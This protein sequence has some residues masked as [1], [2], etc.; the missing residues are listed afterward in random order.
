MS[1]MREGM[2]GNRRLRVPVSGTVVVI[3]LTVAQGLSASDRE[4]RKAATW[5]WPSIARFEESFQSYL[6]QRALPEERRREVEAAWDSQSP[7]STGPEA[8]DH[9]LETV[10]LADD[11]FE[12]IWLQLKKPLAVRSA[13]Q[14][15]DLSWWDASI[16]PWIQ[17][18]FR[19]GVARYLAHLQFYDESLQLLNQIEVSQVVDP[20]T[21]FFYRAVCHHHLLQKDDCV[22]SIK[23]MMERESELASR[24]AITA[25]LMLADIEPLQE[26]SLDEISRLMNDV[27]RRLDLGRS[28]TVVRAQEQQIIEK[29]DKMIDQIEQQLQEQQRQQQQQQAQSDKSK[30][31]GKPME[32]SRVAGAS[33]PGDVDPKKIGDRG[34]WGDLP[35][36][37]RQEALQ[38]MTKDLPSHYREVIESYF[39]ALATGTP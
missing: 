14:A 32:D 38:N 8:L 11:R 37:Q 18:N 13:P 4:L 5:Q 25:K 15:I 21:L 19:L 7:R 34:G 27:Q 16:P 1:E 36:A 33:G 6:Q 31:Q 12:R 26:D 35:P 22:T 24:Y 9:L 23:L 30:G 39:K 10:A 3:L 28:G 17:D 20:S 29:L 2:V